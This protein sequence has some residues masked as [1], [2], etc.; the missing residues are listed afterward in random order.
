[1]HEDIIEP[2]EMVRSSGNPTIQLCEGNAVEDCQWTF[3]PAA[4]QVRTNSGSV[5]YACID[6]APYT[7]Q[8]DESSWVL[9]ALDPA[10]GSEI[11]SATIDDSDEECNVQ[12]CGEPEEHLRQVATLHVAE[13]LTAWETCEALLD[14]AVKSIWQ[15]ALSVQ[16]D[17]RLN[18]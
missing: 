1:M 13:S 11:A 4:F 17:V 5:K 9:V 18:P 8:Y 14:E 16:A 10:T 6:C 3:A 7:K 12:S 2:A 15:A